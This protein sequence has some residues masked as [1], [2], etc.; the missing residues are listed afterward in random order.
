[1][2][3]LHQFISTTENMQKNKKALVLFNTCIRA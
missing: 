2:Q 3:S 1:M